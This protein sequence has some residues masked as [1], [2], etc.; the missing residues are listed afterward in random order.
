MWLEGSHSATKKCTCSRAAR[1]IKIHVSDNTN[2]ALDAAN[3]GVI[4]VGCYT[5]TRFVTVH[6]YSRIWQ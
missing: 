4:Q 1:K 2:K 5:V 6:F 3:D